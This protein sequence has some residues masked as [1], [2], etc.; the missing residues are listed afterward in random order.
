MLT[1]YKYPCEI[2]DRFTIDLPAGAKVLTVQVQPSLM[3]EHPHI[4][5][6]VDPSHKAISRSFRLAGTGHP[7]ANE[8]MRYVGTVQMGNGSLEFHLFEYLET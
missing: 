5:A 2:L 7:V 4:W 6:L 8:P 1:V 3:G